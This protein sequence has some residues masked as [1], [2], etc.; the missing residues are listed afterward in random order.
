MKFLSTGIFSF[1]MVL[2]LGA[3]EPR[4]QEQCSH[5]R[6]SPNMAVTSITYPGWVA[7][8][9]PGGFP[10]PVG[11]SG[12][13]SY[14]SHCFALGMCQILHVPCK[15]EVSISPGLQSHMLWALIFLIQDFQA[16]EP[17]QRLG[18]LT[19]VGEPLQH[20]SPVCGLPARGYGVWLYH[21][22]T[23]P[24]CLTVVLPLCPVVKNLF[25]EVLFHQWWF[26]R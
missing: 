20:C 8:T 4:C 13:G 24:T 1:W 6:I 19:V 12:P 5:H 11:R 23:R 17:N 18:I 7:A 21:D 15:S 22:S 14:E 16:G 2:S 9:S 26:W 25:W 3:N 10:R